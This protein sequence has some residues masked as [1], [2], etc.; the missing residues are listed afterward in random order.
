MIILNRRNTLML[1]TVGA[2][3][4]FT[5]QSA[6][7]LDVIPYT[8]ATLAQTQAGGQPFLLD[9]YADWCS[10]CK[11]QEQVLGQLYQSNP[12]YGAILIIRVDWDENERG[13]LVR[14]MAIPRRST[15]VLMRG[16]TEIGRLVAET[17]SDAI[18]ALLDQAGS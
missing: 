2:I 7:A 8:E 12:A 18:A 11:A 5:A 10:T 9:F 15:L 6:A 16:D 13:E 1:V 3:A 4:A 17:G 14:A